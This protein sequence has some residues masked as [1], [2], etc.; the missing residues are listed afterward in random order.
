MAYSNCPN[1]FEVYD[2]EKPRVCKK[3]GLPFNGNSENNKEYVRL[4][5]M[6]NSKT[7]EELE[8]I[9][10]S[11]EEYTDIAKCVAQDII[12][13]GRTEYKEQVERYKEEQRKQ[14]S[15]QQEKYQNAL[16]NPLYDDIHQIAG[17]LRFIKNLIIVSIVCGFVLG[18]I[19]VIG[20]L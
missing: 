5:A 20:M 14:K 9:I 16:T 7:T 11:E 12:D 2:G 8:A 13:T 3:C 1:C 17:D 15:I 6:F 18:I 10:S 4:F 19:G